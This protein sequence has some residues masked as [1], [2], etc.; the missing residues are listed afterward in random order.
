MRRT[1]GAIAVAGSMVAGTVAL[2]AA[3]A[4]AAD[5]S[6]CAGQL[7]R[8]AGGDMASVTADW[9]NDFLGVDQPAGHY[10]AHIA[11]LRMPDCPPLP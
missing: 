7:G 8:A 9:R 6:V 2:L 10:A 3:P 5:Q 11:H 1:L 4:S